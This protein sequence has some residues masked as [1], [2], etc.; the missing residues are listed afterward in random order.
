MSLADLKRRLGLAVGAL[1]A[2]TL[3]AVAD[4]CERRDFEGTGYAV[5]TVT[6]DRQDRL[7]LWLDDDSGKTL[8][9]FTAVR[10]TLGSGEVLGFAMNAGMFHPDYAPVGL[11][12]SGGVERGQLVTAGGFPGS[13]VPLNCLT[14][15]GSTIFAGL[16]PFMQFP[17]AESPRMGNGSKDQEKNCLMQ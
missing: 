7:R 9:D 16:N 4:L 1:V 17:Q 2:M 12:R 10:R 13:G 6:G 14:L 3:P 11:Y 5:C 15:Y 8:G